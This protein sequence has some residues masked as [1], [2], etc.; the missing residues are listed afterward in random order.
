LP[1][2]KSGITAGILMA[3]GRAFGETMAVTMVIGN[4]NVMPKGL[5][6]PA[7]T[8][9]SLIANEFT[10]AVSRIHLSSLIEIGLVL[11]IISAVFSIMGKIF[12][13]KFSIT[14]NG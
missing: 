10:E 6:S 12:I 2:A 9:A 8:M 7:N 13:H 14:E 5:F 11:F 4:S 3:L 1:Y